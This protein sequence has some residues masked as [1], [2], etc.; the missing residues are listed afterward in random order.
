MS[1]QRRGHLPPTPE[2][3]S[4]I[5]LPP[6]PFLYTVDQI[7]VLLNLDER[8]L[9]NHLIHF[10]GRSIGAASRDHLLARNISH[11]DKAPDWRVAEQEL[12]RWMKRKGF[13]YYDRGTVTH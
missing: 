10:E 6:R 2:T 9:K 3:G 8:S 11:P 12:I 4:K 7:S 5:G 1:N 13:K